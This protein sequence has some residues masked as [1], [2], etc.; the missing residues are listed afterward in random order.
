MDINKNY[1][2][3]LGLDK[4]ADEKVIKKAFRNLSKTHHPDKGGSAEEFSKISEAYDV[5]KDDADK[6]KYDT[7]S[8][9]GKSYQPNPFGGGGGGFGRGSHFEDM[10]NNFNNARRGGHGFDHRGNNSREHFNETL[11]IKMSPLN[12]TLSETYN[13][14]SKTF[15]YKRKVACSLCDARGTVE[16]PD[17]DECL[18][19]NSKGKVYGQECKQC[20]GSGRI[21][22]KQCDRCKGEK[23]SLKDEVISISTY[24]PND[25]VTEYK[26]MGNSSKYTRGKKGDL[27]VTVN[28]KPNDEYTISGYDLTKTVKM[29]IKTAVLGG[30]IIF[31]HLDEVKD[32]DGAMKRKK[33]E[34]KIPART[35]NGTKFRLKGLGLSANKSG[36]VRGNLWI[37]LE[38]DIDFEKLTDSDMKLISKLE[39]NKE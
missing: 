1:Y 4:N 16:S 9:N 6:H 10:L 32:K 35:E 33:R 14:P 37:V 13:N 24:N 8:P 21:H 2:K 7:Q 27:V 26:G 11:D 19:C 36:K 17:S 23:V 38:L 28:M 15:Q 12:L 18:S 39:L 3:I 31:E 25:I 30:G 29:D 20:S 34:F 5:L 22:S